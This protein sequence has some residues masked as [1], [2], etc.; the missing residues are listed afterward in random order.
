MKHLHG[1]F[2][3]ETYDFDY[4]IQLEDDSK[5][6]KKENELESIEEHKNQTYL[7]F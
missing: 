6:L 7:E 1:V 5:S 2:N 4:I 3:F